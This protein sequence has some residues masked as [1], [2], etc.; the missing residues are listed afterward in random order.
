MSTESF[1]YTQIK[2]LK[3]IESYKLSVQLITFTRCI[4]AML[5]WI[6]PIEI[7]LNNY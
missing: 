3:R 4:V 7:N 2:E 6:V 5:N 1:N